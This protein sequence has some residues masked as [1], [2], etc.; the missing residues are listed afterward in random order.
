M[1]RF[2][3]EVEIDDRGLG[4]RFP[5]VF[6]VTGT[7]TG[8]GKTFIS[9]V[10][11]KGLNAG[12]W[13][14]IQ[15]G[16]YDNSPM[17]DGS[18]CPDV[19]QTD[20]DWVR[21]NTGLP[22]E[23]FYPE[24]YRLSQ[25]LSPHLA[26]ALDR[27]DI[28]LSRITLPKFQQDRLIVEGAGGL[29]VP[30]NEK[31]LI[32][33][34]VEHLK[35]PV[36]LVSRS[37]LGTINHTLLSLAALRQRNIDIIGVVMNGVTNPENAR[38]I[39]HYGRVPVIA[40]VPPIAPATTYSISAAFNAFFGERYE[41]NGNIDPDRLPDMASVHANEDCRTTVAGKTR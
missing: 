5:T 40:Q 26:A 33:D 9:A 35:L 18:E 10:L 38:A 17:D 34:M 16:N 6:F 32:I 25:P 37:G 22:K 1:S 11:C 3:S 21:A 4:K 14:P 36:L 12:Y 7:D 31:Q 39:E 20:T 15:S 24:A 8:V 27:T 19:I 29:L 30:L 23:H 41:V 13:K 2:R 28:Q